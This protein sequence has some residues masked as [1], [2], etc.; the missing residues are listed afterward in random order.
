MSERTGPLSDL[1]ILDLTQALAGPFCTMLLADL[2]ADVIKVE[3]PLGDMARY[4]GPHPDD[5]ETC[6]YGGYFAS[7]NRNKRSIVLNL[8]TQADRDT[9]LQLAQTVDAVV[10]NARVGV[11]DRL[12]LGYETLRDHNP[13]IVYAAIRGFGDPRT[14]ESPYAEWPAFDIVAQSMGGMVSTTG[15]PGSRGMPA[16]ASVGDLFPGTL[17][18]L[19]I[20]SAVHAAR[21]SGEGQFLDVAMYDGVLL[22]CESIV[23]RFSA[24]GQV[25]PPKGFGH[26]ALSPFDVF[27]TK[28]GAAAIAAPKDEQWQ[29]LCE[30]IGRP[31]LVDDERTV[32]VLVRVTH[33]ELVNEAILAWTRQNPTQAVVAALAGKVPVGPVNTAADIFTDPHPK[34]RGMLVEIAQPGNNRPITLAGPPIKLTGTPST[35]YRRPPNIGEHSEEILAEAGIESARKERP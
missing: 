3:P 7:I 34:I 25:S 11:F 13:G 6:Q 10:E 26:P 4:L 12:G 14:G 9:F 30:V 23:Y 20:V 32:N 28:N 18:A 22:L 27:E 17:A 33:R 29:A 5:R 8:K 31:D 21:R 35:I 1:R 2:G 19:G 24:D 16:G 15:P